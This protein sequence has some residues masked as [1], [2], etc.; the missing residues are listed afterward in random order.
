[1][2][3]RLFGESDEEQLKN[4]TKKVVLTG[5]GVVCYILG[6]VF[7]LMHLDSVG[8]IFGSIGGIALLVAMFMWGFGAIKRLMGIGT[9]GAIFSGNVVFGVVIFVMCV[10]VAYFVSLIVAFIGIGRYIYLRIKMAQERG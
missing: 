2:F 3:V 5:I 8:G 6:L 7:Y 1:M 9:V 10:I 4:L